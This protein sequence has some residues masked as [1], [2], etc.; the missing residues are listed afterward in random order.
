MNVLGITAEYNPFHKGH[1]Y[2]ME[3]SKDIT[4]A[5]CTVVVMSGNFT[6]RGEAAVFDKWTRSKM[7]VEEG[8]DLV[9]ELPFV[10]ACN[11]A[12]IFA[13]GAVDILRGLGVTHISF[14][15]ECGDLEELKGL[16]QGFIENK[17][18]IEEKRTEFMKEGYSFA[19]GT[20]MACESIFGRK[21]SQLLIKPNNILAIE[22][23]KRILYW[24]GKGE[25]LYA[26]AVSRH[27]S[28]YFQE[29]N[30]TGFAGASVIRELISKRD[31]K[32]GIYVTENTAHAIAENTLYTQWKE[33]AFNI[34]RSDIIRNN[35]KTLSDI[36]CMGEGI[37]NKLKKEIITAGSWDDLT[38]A[39]TS[40]RY[41]ESAVRRLMIYILVGLKEKHPAS[42][43]Y[44]RVL[45]AGEKGRKLIRKIKKEGKGMIPVI[46]NINKDVVKFPF[47]SKMLDYDCIASDMYNLIN[48]RPLY[49]FSDKVIRPYIKIE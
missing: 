6:Q 14:G 44:A 47:V 43:K 33:E 8:A 9:V 29:N 11:R 4:K 49:D 15:T 17:A 28:G 35:T 32:V 12:E 39:V 24:N 16:A 30:E 27:G 37:E 13:E 22:Y 7:A 36:Y 25:N 20:H 34:I 23:I 18:E 19:K 46:T 42:A 2:H 38:K 5:D 1:K 41:T 40:R 21:R 48:G 31:E 45:A 10:F 26:T 3:K